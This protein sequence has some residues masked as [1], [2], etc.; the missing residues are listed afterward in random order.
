[1]VDTKTLLKCKCILASFMSFV[2]NCAVGSEYSHHVHA[3]EVL[4]ATTPKEM[5]R[6]VNLKTFG[7]TEF[8]HNC[9]IGSEYSHD[10][11][12]A[13][14]VLAAT[15]PKEMLRYMNLKTFGTTEPAG[16]VHTQLLHV[17]IH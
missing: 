6:Y 5:L 3:M 9:A 14:E 13:M 16:D 4:A 17:Q 8:V 11:V 15:T 7:T 12:H 2:H 10:H 1:M